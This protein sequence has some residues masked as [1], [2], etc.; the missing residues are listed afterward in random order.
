VRFDAEYYARHYVD[1]RTRVASARE[2][3]RLAAL[4]GAALD[5]YGL[6]VARILDAGC[7]LGLWKAPLHERYPRATYVGLEVSEYLCKKLGW[8]RASVADYASEEAFDLVI[9]QGVLQ[10]LDDASARRALAN[11]GRLCRGALYLEA[12]TRRDWRESADRS[13]TDGEVRLRT[14]DWYRSALARNF[15]N[16]GSGVFVRRTA[17]VVTWELERAD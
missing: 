4:V 10:Y 6:R 5:H 11:L 2:T 13:R 15:T 16:V 7:G 14:G 8:T 9:C 12:L 1:P 3:E 17:A